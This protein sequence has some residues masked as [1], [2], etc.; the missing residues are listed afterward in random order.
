MRV[1]FKGEK[2][3]ISNTKND[4]FN[5]FSSQTPNTYNIGITNCIFVWFEL[6]DKI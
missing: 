4:D 3:K 2:I 1:V 6:L 5:S